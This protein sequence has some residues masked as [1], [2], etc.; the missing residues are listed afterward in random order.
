M[1]GLLQMVPARDLENL[2]CKCRMNRLHVYPSFFKQFTEFG[3]E[4]RYSAPRVVG[5]AAMDCDTL[6]EK[7]RR[8]T[9][10]AASAPP[11]HAEDYTDEQWQGY[12]QYIACKIV[13]AQ[14]EFNWICQKGS[15]RKGKGKDK[16]PSGGGAGACGHRPTRKHTSSPFSECAPSSSCKSSPSCMCRAWAYNLELISY[17]FTPVNL[18]SGTLKFE[19][20]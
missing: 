19:F 12:G 3:S 14:A 1:L 13:Q 7:K 20:L 17:K 4:R 18:E 10:A 6:A 8:A 5:G 16:G 11:R 15:G 9:P 2:L